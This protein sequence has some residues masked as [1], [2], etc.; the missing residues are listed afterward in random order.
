RQRRSPAISSY[1]PSSRGRTTTGWI[2]PCART[3]SA[4]PPTPSLSNRLRGWRGFG[5]IWSTGTCASSG[6]PP[7]ST[8]KPRPRPRRAARPPTLAPLDKLHRH[9][10]VGLGPARPSVVVGHGQPVARR[11]GDTNRARD[12]RVED[13]GAEVLPHLGFDLRRETC[14]RVGHR[15]QHAGDRERRVEPPL[16]ELDRLYELR[17]AL[18]RVVLGLH[19]HDDAVR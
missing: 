3:D 10:P 18:E 12:D 11:L 6:P 2:N 15:E 19:R 7:I 1:P 13:E 8:S 4:R 17:E 9:L 16:H 14:A 5:W